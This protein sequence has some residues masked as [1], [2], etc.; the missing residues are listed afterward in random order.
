L[1]A[2][3]QPQS[4]LM[5]VLTVDGKWTILPCKVVRR[6][7][8]RVKITANFNSNGTPI[9][10]AVITIGGQPYARAYIHEGAKRYAAGPVELGGDF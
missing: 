9:T 3:S 2:I 6:G 5:S 10:K 8:A 7:A 1:Q 4:V